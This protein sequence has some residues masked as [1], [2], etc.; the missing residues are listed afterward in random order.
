[1]TVPSSIASSGVMLDSAAVSGFAEGLRGDVLQ[2]GDEGYDAARMVWNGMIDKHPALIARCAGVSDVISSVHFAR[3]NG[4]LVAVRGG[5]HN[6][7]GNAVCDGGIVIDLSPMNGIRVDP[8]ARTARAEAGATWGHLDHETQAFGLA[9]TGGTVSTTGIAGLTLGGGLGWLMGTQGLA[10]DNLLSADV[11]TADGTLLTASPTENPDLFWG[12]RGGGGNFGVVTSFEYRL[13]PVGQILGGL[14]TYPLDR[15]TELLESYRELTSSAP[16]ELGIVFGLLSAEDGTPQ[17]A[18][19]VCYNGPVEAGERLLQPLLECATPIASDIVPRPYLEM[20]TMLDEVNPPG[21]LN[22]WKSGFLKELSA[23]GIE[24][25]VSRFAGVTS[26]RTVVLVEHVGGAVTRVGPDETA[27][28][29][30]HSPCNLMIVSRWTDPAESE[31]HIR[32]TR[33]FWD[34][35][36]PYVAEGVY[37]NYLG[38]N[39]GEDRV[40]AAFGGADKY[41]RLVALK[42]KYDPT[43]LF[44]QNQNIVPT[45]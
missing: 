13:H 45:P 3:R 4:L 37:V 26:R 43:N 10:C 16:D 42:N 8:I 15:A 41:R 34:A 1:M 18:I 12:V 35:M 28:S 33:E 9:T 39:E 11:I 22:Y 40:V 23:P 29:H 20:Q 5:G 25:I 6:V 31:V 19:L 21:L 27:F 24:T 17:V 14:A 38:E 32:W 36:Q 44:R 30:R 2:P 7:A